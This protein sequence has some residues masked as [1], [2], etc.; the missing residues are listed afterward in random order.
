MNA[1]RVI[2]TLALVAGLEPAS[3]A[4]Q[5][6]LRFEVVPRAGMLAPMREIGPA[7]RAGGPWYLRLERADA[8]PA[9]E[10]EIR[11]SGPGSRLAARLVG[12]ATLPADVSGFFDCYPGL[13]C[14]AVLLPSA[15]EAAVLAAAVDVLYSPLRGVQAIRPFAALG[16]GVKRYRITWP[17]AAVLVRGGEHSESTPTVRAGAG[18]EFAVLGQSV[19]AEVADWWSPEGRKISEDPG[20][21]GLSAPR[22]RAQHDIAVSLGW[23]LLRF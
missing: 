2:G 10:M 9:F 3:V 20:L 13:A 19:R 5:A 23:R 16:V 22:R 7:A 14:P 6:P 11:V 1:G 21:P 15:A 17:D 8:A 4:A 12:L 18:V